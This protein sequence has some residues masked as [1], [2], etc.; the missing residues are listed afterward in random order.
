MKKILLISLVLML[1]AACT[2]KPTQPP[3]NPRPVGQVTIQP[4]EP[5]RTFVGCAFKVNHP[6]NFVPEENGQNVEFT[7]PSEGDVA[8]TIMVRR[9]GKNEETAQPQ[10]IL[11]KLI[12]KNGAAKI[13]PAVG[14]FETK[15]DAGNTLNG[16]QTDFIL[17]QIHYRL[18]VIIRPSTKLT[19]GLSAD[20]V[21]EIVATAPE[22]VWYVWSVFYKDYFASFEPKD[23]E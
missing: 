6:G 1:I 5:V 10:D 13:R 21:Y 12:E 22:A 7:A 18:V 14:A 15:D 3:I 17:D 9:R 20:A 8:A 2:A 19:D 11:Q 23:C 4:P 16:A